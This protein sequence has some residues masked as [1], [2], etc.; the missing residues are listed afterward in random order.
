MHL[1]V[2]N[3]GLSDTQLVQLNSSLQ[4]EAQH[5][6]GELQLGH[7]YELSLDLLDA[8]NHPSGDC[9]FCLNTLCSS[10]NNEETAPVV[11]LEC[12][13]C[14]HRA[15]FAA[16]YNWSQV[17]LATRTAEILEEYKAMSDQRL[18]EE[19]I[20]TCPDGSYIVKCPSCRLPI[21]PASLAHLSVELAAHQPSSWTEQQEQLHLNTDQLQ[22][23]KA[24]Q[25]KMAAVA[26]KQRQCGG[27]VEASVGVSLGELQ[28]MMDNAR[29]AAEEADGISKE[30]YQQ[31]PQEPHHHQNGH[32]HTSNRK[33]VN[34][35]GAD[36]RS[37]QQKEHRKSKGGGRGDGGV[38]G[39]HS[40]GGRRGR[41]LRR[42]APAAVNGV[43]AAQQ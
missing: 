13:H 14:Y 9:M 3:A 34:G 8:E 27:L 20:E 22:Q 19:G 39:R 28:Q 25:S 18:V 29:L 17:R 12:F 40:S 31:G 11:K 41:G 4:A 16:W 36:G 33:Y 42:D 30:E 5:M 43:A 37:G 7:L 6:A 2:L 26:E 24:T 32:H 38:N 1:A 35:G 23:L 10:S 21:P 15:C